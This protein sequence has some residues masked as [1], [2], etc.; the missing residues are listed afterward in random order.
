[1]NRYVCS[2][3]NHKFTVRLVV[4]FFVVGLT[5][6]FGGCEQS[7]NSTIEPATGKV[8]GT[9]QL[10]IDFK[11]ERKNINADVPCSE[12]STVFTILERAQNLGDVKF[13]ATG[14][15]DPASTFVNSIGGVENLAA[16]GDNWIY[17]VNEELGDKSSALYSV[18]P[19][20]EVT[21]VFGK[22]EPE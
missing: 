19:G 4:T 7:G 18:K 16:K 13:K 11:S 20:D 17:L 15:S 12:D 5:C 9:V 6:L 8:A 2:V 22:Y 14:Q 1:M 3:T 10:E 21:W